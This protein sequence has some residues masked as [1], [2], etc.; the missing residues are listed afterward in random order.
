[1]HQVITKRMVK[2]QQMCWTER[3]VHLLLQVRTQ[4]LNDDLRATFK[5]WYPGMKADPAPAE[6]AAA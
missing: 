6:E 5:R 3:G 4:G 1:M 2:K